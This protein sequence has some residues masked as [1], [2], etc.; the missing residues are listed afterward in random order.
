M[1]SRTLK[2]AAERAAAPA[3]VG[4]S[5]VAVVVSGPIQGERRRD[6]AKM[7]CINDPSSNQSTHVLLMDMVSTCSC[8]SL[9]KLCP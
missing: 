3:V 1:I 4:V 8:C 5:G 9:R 7:W 2:I 6:K